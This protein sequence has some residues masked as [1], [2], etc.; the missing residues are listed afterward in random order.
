MTSLLLR[1]SPYLILALG[2]LC[3]LLFAA[4]VDLVAVAPVAEPRHQRL[5][6]EELLSLSG[7][8][9]IAL[10]AIALFKA[11]L[12]TRERGH[13]AAAEEVANTDPLTGLSNRRRFFNKLHSAL[14]HDR[15]E[16][17]CALLLIDLDRFKEVNDT[18]GHAAGDALLVEIAHR[19]GRVASQAEHA[20]RLG[21]DEFGLLLEGGNASEF[22]ARSIVCRLLAEVGK[23]FEHAGTTIRPGGSIGLAIA[24]EASTVATLMEAADADMY[25]AKR[26]RRRPAAA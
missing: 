17:G 1:H 23:P 13:R 22:G 19:L 16:H 18:L 5:E 15:I 6:L 9:S 11:H 25:R 20:A 8:F 3:S 2:F 21:G 26:E 4:E 24:D 14:S 12:V 7:L 10:A